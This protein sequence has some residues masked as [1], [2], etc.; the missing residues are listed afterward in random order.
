[1]RIL[2]D[3]SLPRRLKRELPGHDVSTVPEKGWAGKKNGELIRLAARE[4]DV[5]VTADQN[6]IFQQNLSNIRIAW[7][8]LVAESNRFDAL[9][10]LM[11]HVI[12]ALETIGPG[13][14]VRISS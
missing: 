9:M 1:M 6:L 10:P 2:I 12:E 5:F 11:P 3:E 14:I 7:I 13:D 4:F 8:L